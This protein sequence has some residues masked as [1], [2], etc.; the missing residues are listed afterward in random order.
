MN[1]Q[2]KFL[3]CVNCNKNDECSME[4]QCQH[5]ICVKCTKIELIAIEN[6]IRV[7][8]ILKCNYCKVSTIIRKS[9]AQ[10]ILDEKP[11]S[12]LSVSDTSIKSR[13]AELSKRLKSANRTPRKDKSQCQ[14]RG[15]KQKHSQTRNSKIN[16]HAFNAYQQCKESEV[17]F[18]NMSSKDH[19]SK[20]LHLLTSIAKDSANKENKPIKKLDRLRINTFNSN[21]ADDSD[22]NKGHRPTI[23]NLFKKSRFDNKT[24][25]AAETKTK[26]A[27][28]DNL[29][30][31]TYSDT[32]KEKIPKNNEMPAENK[33]KDVIEYHVNK[34]QL[35]GKKYNPMKKETFTHINNTP[36]SSSNT[37]RSFKPVLSDL[38]KIEPYV[39]LDIP[40]DKSFSKITFSEYS[41]DYISKIIATL[42][43]NIN[44]KARKYMKDKERILGLKEQLNKYFEQLI[45]LFSE[46]QDEYNKLFQDLLEAENTIYSRQYKDDKTFKNRLRKIQQTRLERLS[47]SSRAYSEFNEKLQVF[48]SVASKCKLFLNDCEMVLK[49]KLVHNSEIENKLNNK[50][51]INSSM[52]EQKELM[53]LKSIK[54]VRRNSLALEITDKNLRRSFDMRNDSSGNVN[55][56]CLE[57]TSV[58]HKNH[59]TK[60]DLELKKLKLML[61]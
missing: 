46:K 31:G 42:E 53:V 25:K 40:E 55:Y 26:T 47:V 22:Q 4:L 6:R 7:D 37:K 24:S 21:N 50:I 52:I 28:N 36:R 34:E 19:L 5:S 35:S 16:L 12:S 9:E 10:K 15:N 58:T 56:F 60:I 61:Q 18:S 45:M 1:C 48:D 29:P 57:S 3:S 43:E 38:S 51:I 33:L 39:P 32:V 14:S 44:D 2:K 20:T 59:R 17:T 54:K 49:Q 30:E 11:K 13:I 23:S 27:F 41:G 8:K